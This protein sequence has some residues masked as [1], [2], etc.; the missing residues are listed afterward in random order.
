[1]ASVMGI[2]GG[3]VG[4]KSENVEKVLVFKAFFEGSRGPRG[5]QGKFAILRPLPLGGGR[6]RVNPPPRSLFGGFGG[7]GGLEEGLSI[8]TGASN[9][10]GQGVWDWVGRCEPSPLEACLEV[11]EIC[12]V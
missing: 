10:T 6:E 12:R 9:G 7:F 4:P 3:M 2:C 5:R 1:M 11:L 8:L